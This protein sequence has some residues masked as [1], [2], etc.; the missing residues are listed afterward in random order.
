MSAAQTT[1]QQ[2]ALHLDNVFGHPGST[3]AGVGVI[4]MTLSQ[5]MMTVPQPTSSF[6]WALFG[7]QM[8]GG[9]GALL[10]K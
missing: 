1:A 2:P 6:G 3:L 8:L 10:G 9:I 4:G 7:L 5:A